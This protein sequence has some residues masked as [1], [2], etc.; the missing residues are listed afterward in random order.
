MNEHF[1]EIEN[2]FAA[3]EKTIQSP[4]SLVSIPEKTGSGEE[5]KEANP[6]VPATIQHAIDIDLFEGDDDGLI[7]LSS[8]LRKNEQPCSDFSLAAFPKPIA[9]YIES[10]SKT[11]KAHPIMIAG[12]VLTTISAFMGRRF[13]IPESRTTEGYYQNLYPNLWILCLTKSGQFKSTALS[14]GSELAREHSLH[15]LKEIDALKNKLSTDSSNEEKDQLEAAIIRLQQ[16]DV[17]FPTRITPEALLDMLASGIGGMFLHSEIAGWLQNLENN[18]YKAIFTDLFD[19]PPI[20]RYKTKHQ[21]DNIILS[22]F[23]SIFG[24]SN[25]AWVKDKTK[26]SD[27][28]SGFFPRFL[29]YAPPHQEGIPDALP[30]ASI[31]DDHQ[32]KNDMIYYLDL[33]TG[34]EERRY[35]LSPSAQTAFQKF[36]I[37]IYEMMKT[38]PESSKEILEPY[39]KR[40][41]PYVLKLA[42]IMQFFFD[43]ATDEISVEA[44]KA[45][46][47]FITPAI[48][49]TAHLFEGELGESEEETHLRKVNDFI[50]KRAKKDDKVTYEVISTSKTIKNKDKGKQYTYDEILGILIGQGKIE[51]EVH[52]LKKKSLYWPVK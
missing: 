3:S 19:V 41:S 36:H 34:V 28:P 32:P 47:S 17:L 46:I 33:L 10:I 16:E 39:V 38:Y 12:A 5:S 11:T 24:V 9:D 8:K 37:Q 14:K 20:Y 50:I 6:L 15:I 21:G 42:M 26:P 18:D 52:A 27:V 51:C 35:R 45:A 30:S 49:S 29:L 4:E 31:S 2:T 48:K 13:Y 22:P 25:V 43:T 7:D 1:N 23:M 44:I 40:W